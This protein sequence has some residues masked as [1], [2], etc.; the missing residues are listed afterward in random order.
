[1]NGSVNCPRPALLAGTLALLLVACGGPPPA[2]TAETGQSPAPAASVGAGGGGVADLCAVLPKELA[3]AAMGATV[4]DGEGGDLFPEGSYCVFATDDAAVRVEVQ[5]VEMTREAFDTQ[6]N[7]FGLT[8]VAEGAGEAAFV[9][10]TSV[11]GAAGT[12]LYAYGNGAAIGVDI[13]GPDDQAAQL[14]AART[15]VAAVLA[16]SD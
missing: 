13:Q 9:R 15:I 1:M 8:E 4:A 16:A 12:W 7:S 6:A 10:E 14:D 5:R 3:E 11:Q 2:S